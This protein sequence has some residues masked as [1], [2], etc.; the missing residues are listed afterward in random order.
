LIHND[1][2]ED[3][4]RLA[5]QFAAEGPHTRYFILLVETLAGDRAKRGAL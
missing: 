3:A 5:R 1:R 4:R 2:L